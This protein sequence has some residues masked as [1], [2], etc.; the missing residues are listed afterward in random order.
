M[1]KHFIGLSEQKRRARNN[2]NE[3]CFVYDKSDR[4]N[5]FGSRKKNAVNVVNDDDNND[6]VLFPMCIE[7]LA[8]FFACSI[9]NG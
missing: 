2:L 6:N 3:V 7:A 5:R 8:F 4:R 1:W 9:S